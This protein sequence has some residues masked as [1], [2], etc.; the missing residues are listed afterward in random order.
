MNLVDNEL[1][2]P[3]SIFTYRY[4]LTNWPWLC[5]LV[6]EGPHCFG[7]VVCRLDNHKN[8]QRGYLAMLVVEK[9][10]RSRGVG[11]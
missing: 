9:E 6:R 4:F 8:R 5:F 10:F 11:E 1:S 7:T 3:Y 2:E